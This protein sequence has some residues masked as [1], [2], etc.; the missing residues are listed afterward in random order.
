M[1]TSS[2]LL[3]LPR[4]YTSEAGL[5][6]TSTTASPGRTPDAVIAFTS[7]AT[8]ARIF[9]AIL[10]PSRILAVIHPR[11]VCESEA[12]LSQLPTVLVGG[13]RARI[14]HHDSAGSARRPSLPG[15]QEAAGI[16]R[17]STQLEMRRMPPRV[18]HTGWYSDFADRRSVHRR[19]LKSNCQKTAPWRETTQSVISGTAA[20]TTPL[21]RYPMFAV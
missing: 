3:T 11:A 8:S 19:G 21:A 1:P 12:I 9:A 17:E 18:S 2:E 20:V 4:T 15:L 10:L 7:A 6:P 13:I 14:I 16:E 5:C